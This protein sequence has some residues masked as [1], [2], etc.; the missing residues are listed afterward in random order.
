MP[1]YVTNNIRLTGG[2]PETI[3]KAINFLKSEHSDVD[4]NN[5]VEMPE[6]L[7]HTEAGSRADQAWAYYQSKGLGNHSAID[8]I[9]S[10]PWV[11]NEGIKTREELLDWFLKES[12]NIY[13]YGEELYNLEKTY[14][15]HDWYEWSCKY[16][17][18]KW[19]ACDACSDE[20]AGTAFFQTAWSDVGGLIQKFSALF[21][22]LDVEYEYADEDY[23]CNLGRMTFKGGL[24]TDSYFPENGSEEA[25]ALAEEI[26]GYPL[27]DEDDYDEEE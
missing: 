5:I 23:G 4:F 27:D 21:P 3:K 19:N 6:A 2:T 20:I 10:Y 8:K 7:K 9:F 13:A 16:W 15:C 1:N 25:Y 12:P 18:T 17:G 14:G 24:M 11:K 22:T 26:L